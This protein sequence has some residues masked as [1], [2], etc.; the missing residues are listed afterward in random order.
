MSKYVLSTCSTADISLEHLQKREIEY[1]KFSFYL[2]DVEHH[3]D[4]GQTISFEDFY[5]KMKNGAETRTSQPNVQQYK[6]YFKPFLKKGLDVIHLNLSSGLSGSYSSAKIAVEELKEEYPD[7]VVY[8]IDSLGASSGMGLLV[9]KMADLRDEGMSIDEL[10]K[11]TEEN[12]LRLHHWFFA[13][14]LTFFVKG[15]RVSKVAGWFGTVLK[16]CPLLNVDNLGRLIPREK[17]RGKANVM[18]QIVKKM[19]ENAD[20]GLEYCEKCY[21]SH[22]D[23]LEDAEAVARMIEEKF[24][25]LKEKVLINSIGTTIGAHTGPGTVAVFFFGKERM[26]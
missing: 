26:N 19:E 7:R 17:I 22:S 9:D 13:T 8:V 15:G 23:S 12:K 21:I 3:D 20:N 11:W 1:I 5:N 2:D 14:D 24:P 25:S 6:D 4:L 10:Y 18:K 16:I